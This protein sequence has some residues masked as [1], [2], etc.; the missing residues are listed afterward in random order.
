MD[1]GGNLQLCTP[2]QCLHRHR[3]GIGLIAAGQCHQLC[4]PHRPQG[5]P[6][7]GKGLLRAEREI[8]FRQGSLGIFQ[9]FVHRI[10][11]LVQG[12]ELVFH[13]LTV[14][15]RHAHLLS[16]VK[17]VIERIVGGIHQLRKLA[18]VPVPHQHTPRRPHSPAGYVIAG[19]GVDVDAVGFRGDEPLRGHVDRG[20]FLVS[21]AVPEVQ[22][23]VRAHVL[24]GIQFIGAVPNRGG[25]D[26]AHVF[27]LPGAV[28]QGAIRNG[29][30]I[31]VEIDDIRLPRLVQPHHQTHRRDP[32]IG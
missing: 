15:D 10:P 11:I 32:V 26:L 5:F 16:H 22:R 13:P 28:F 20:N 12:K 6:L 29:A 27:Q 17:F 21:L 31:L 7:G 24:H 30:A 25:A 18:E 3:P 1:D 8:I 2:G 9:D 23:L 19:A 14:D 4:L